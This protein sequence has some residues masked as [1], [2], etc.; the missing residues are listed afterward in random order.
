MFPLDEEVD[1]CLDCGTTSQGLSLDFTELEN[2][3]K[4]EKEVKELKRIWYE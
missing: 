3:K 2:L 4:K 1:A